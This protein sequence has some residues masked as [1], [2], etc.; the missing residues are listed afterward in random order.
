MDEDG[1]D[2]LRSGEELGMDLTGAE[3]GLFEDGPDY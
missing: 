3:M 2:L 1:E